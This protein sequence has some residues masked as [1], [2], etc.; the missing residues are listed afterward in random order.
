MRRRRA[1]SVDL[2]AVEAEALTPA[3]NTDPTIDSVTPGNTVSVEQGVAAPTVTVTASDVDGDIP[4]LSSDG[5]EPVGIVFTDNGDGTG[6]FDGT[7]SDPVAAVRR[8]RHGHR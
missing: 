8:G 5:N 2:D 4:V 3:P 6:T 7:T 1:R